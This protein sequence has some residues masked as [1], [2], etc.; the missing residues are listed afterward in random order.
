MCVNCILDDIRIILETRKIAEQH[1]AH[2]RP[3]L[4]G[5]MEEPEDKI[6]DKMKLLNFEELLEHQAKNN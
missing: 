4:L 6:Y 1:T 5:D 3:I 2:P